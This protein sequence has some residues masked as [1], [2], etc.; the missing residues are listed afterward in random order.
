MIKKR[1]L[2]YVTKL[3]EQLDVLQDMVKDNFGDDPKNYG[4]DYYLLQIENAK[5]CLDNMLINVVDVNKYMD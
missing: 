2:N 4:L 1:T 3:M 5:M